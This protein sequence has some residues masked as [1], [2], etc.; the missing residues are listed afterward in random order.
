M[1][2]RCRSWKL[3][4]FAACLIERATD[5]IL[6][7]LGDAC[8]EEAAWHRWVATTGKATVERTVSSPTG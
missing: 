4:T 2:G 8:R 6:I 1:G 5:A 7:Q 3:G